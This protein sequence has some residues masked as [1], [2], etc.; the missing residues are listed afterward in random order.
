MFELSESYLRKLNEKVDDYVDQ[1][2]K[3]N[4]VLKQDSIRDGLTGCYNHRYFQDIISSE[5]SR[6]ARYNRSLSLAMVDID[7]FKKL[8][9]T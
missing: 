3:I 8:N 2:E 6:A 4:T 9:D 7:D 1:I 5:V